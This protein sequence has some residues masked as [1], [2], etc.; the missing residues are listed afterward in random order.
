ML[1]GITDISH[2]ATTYEE[3]TSW[4]DDLWTAFKPT[5][6]NAYQQKGLSVEYESI[7]QSD[8]EGGV[9]AYYECLVIKRETKANL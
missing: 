9:L 3:N 7:E 8:G 2:L 5:I 1:S 4:I 6:Q